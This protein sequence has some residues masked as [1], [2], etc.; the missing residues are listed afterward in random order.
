MNK[1]V[2]AVEEAI[3]IAKVE[4]VNKEYRAT[5]EREDLGNLAQVN[6]FYFI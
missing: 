6:L 2:K 3:V 1:A 5:I 4:V